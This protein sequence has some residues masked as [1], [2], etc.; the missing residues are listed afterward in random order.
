L[1]I[2]KH[3]A[4]MRHERNTMEDEEN[5]TNDARRLRHLLRT[6]DHLMHARVAQAVDDAQIGRRE[7]MLLN[8]ISGDVRAPGF[9]ERMARRP[10]KLEHLRERGLLTQV[11][12]AWTL[13][14]AG[15]AAK[16]AFARATTSL[17]ED[18]TAAVSPEDLATTLASLESIARALG[19]DDA[20]GEHRAHGRHGR[21]R[22]F[23]PRGGHGFGPGFRHGFGPHP[24][25]EDSESGCGHRGPGAHHRS[26]HH[27]DHHRCADRAAERDT[28]SD[29]A[30]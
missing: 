25:F 14:E 13:T 28:T 12:G 6:V 18:A 3:F 20:L 2:D 11:D 26:A 23:G 17:R 21:G 15:R 8:L 19:A 16:D 5:T 4:A 22:G 10:K 30:S 29:S 9:A 1:Y 27:R 7:W 24:E